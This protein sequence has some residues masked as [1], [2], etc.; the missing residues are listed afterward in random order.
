M[1]VSPRESQQRH[2]L[3]AII[4]SRVGL[5][6]GAQRPRPTA[7]PIW[8]PNGAPRSGT[9]SLQCRP[10][11]RYS[12]NTRAPAV[13]A[14][15]HYM[16]SPATPVYRKKYTNM[17]ESES[18]RVPEEA[19]GPPREGDPPRDPVQPNSVAVPGS[20]QI[21]HPSEVVLG[22]ARLPPA[23]RASDLRMRHTQPWPQSLMADAG[24]L[25]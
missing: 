4:T 14:N 17:G 3:C 23:H 11:P 7:V 13:A 5:R 24:N 25:N 6:P 20:A 12:R 22:R 16:L 9:A 8:A 1:R 10:W 2:K 15:L 18:P 21:R 19:T